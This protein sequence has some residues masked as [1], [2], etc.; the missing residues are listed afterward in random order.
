MYVNSEFYADD[1][2][3]LPLPLRSLKA[4]W[5]LCVPA[6]KRPL[7]GPAATCR[8]SSCGKLRHCKRN[9]QLPMRIGRVS[10]AH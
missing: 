7:P 1:T 6:S 9:T 8:P 2:A 10:R 5:K 4:V 3:K